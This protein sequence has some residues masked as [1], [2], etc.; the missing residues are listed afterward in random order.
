MK[1]LSILVLV[2]LCLIATMQPMAAAD[3]E[4]DRNVQEVAAFFAE[5]KR[6][7]E[8]EDLNLFLQCHATPLPSTDVVRDTITIYTEDMMREE[9]SLLFAM[10]DQIQ[11]DFLD[12][13]VVVDRGLAIAKT[14]R[15]GAAPGMPVVYVRMVFTLR[16][17][18]NGWGS[19]GWK[20]VGDT[21]IDEWYDFTESSSSNPPPGAPSAMQAAKSHGRKSTFW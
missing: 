12:L 8:T 5:L 20:I 2:F 15:R 4:T 13:E 21:L 18:N 1:R 14:L 6:A 3:K 7:Y 9:L 10:L 16:K 11:I 17:G 19:E